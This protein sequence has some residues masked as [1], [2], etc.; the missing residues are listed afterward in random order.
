M[1][2]VY[3]SPRIVSSFARSLLMTWNA[4]TR[5]SPILTSCAISISGRSI[6]R[7]AGSSRASKH[8]R[9]ARRRWMDQ[10]RR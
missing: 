4:T 1:R 3:H 9:V 7:R 6:A 2:L 10:F 5:C 8:R